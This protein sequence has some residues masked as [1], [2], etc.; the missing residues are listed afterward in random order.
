ERGDERR[1]ELALRMTPA[2]LAAHGEVENGRERPSEDLRPV[3]E[4]L[5]DVAGRP[6]AH[7][8]DLVEY[9]ALARRVAGIG[10]H[11]P[12]RSTPRPASSRRSPALTAV[13]TVSSKISSPD[14]PAAFSSSTSASLTAYAAERTVSTNAAA[15][16]GTARSGSA[17]SRSRS[18]R[19]S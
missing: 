13:E 15:T 3:V 6:A 8:F 7:R 2:R 10:T 11:E 17:A 5:E 14:R 12:H 18:T 9:C 16:G 1:E 19:W 4:R